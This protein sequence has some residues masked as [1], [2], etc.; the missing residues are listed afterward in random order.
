[1][2]TLFPYTTLFRS[3]GARGVRRADAI[4]RPA[5]P[6]GQTGRGGS[7]AAALRAVR[8]RLVRLLQPPL[9]REAREPR[10]RAEGVVRVKH[11]RAAPGAR[12]RRAAF[13]A[14]KSRLE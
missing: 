8:R 3:P 14:G 7:A 9:G 5:A 10:V 6:A 1:R 2:V 11:Q 12:P 13:P 4:R